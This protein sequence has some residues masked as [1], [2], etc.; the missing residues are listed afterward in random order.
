MTVGSMS[1]AGSGTGR[2]RASG[3]HVY[4]VVRAEDGRIPQGLT[5][6][7]GSPVYAVPHHEVAAVVGEILLERPAGHRAD[8]LSYSKVL[9]ALVGSGV[10]APV[11]FG[12]VL[13]DVESVVQDL[14]VPNE[15]HFE[16]LLDML[17]GRAQFN[18]GA[19][20][21]DDVALAEIVAADPVIAELRERT[22]VL[23]QHE[24]YGDRV[25]LGELVAHAMEAKRAEDLNLLLDAI[26]PFV[27]AHSVRAGSSPDKVADVA[28]LVDD[29][30]RADLE[31]QLEAVAESVHERIRLRLIGPTAAYDF[32]GA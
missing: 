1:E 11:Q 22:R 15:E 27:A 20:Y 31:A 25:R 4:A 7:D 8:L 14:L 23:G 2:L 16:D 30:R 10:V 26:V 32:V 18:L 21:R 19:A 13:A 12:S 5:G 3:C 24:A 28:L 6:I 17:T 29:D 9:D